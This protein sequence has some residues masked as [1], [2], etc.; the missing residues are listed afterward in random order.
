MD[1]LT[2]KDVDILNG[3]SFELN[4]DVFLVREGIYHEHH[5]S[6]YD[7][8]LVCMW[9]LA[10]DDTYE[11]RIDMIKL[12]SQELDVFIKKIVDYI[13]EKS[14]ENEDEMNQENQESL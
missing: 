14:Q 7:G 6:I 10:G 5:L 3:Y 8:N 12:T 9:A 11:Y 1:N 13:E 4:S 2:L